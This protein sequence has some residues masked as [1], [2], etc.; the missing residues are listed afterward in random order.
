MAGRGGRQ[1]HRYCA[2]GDLGRGPHLQR[3][4]LLQHSRLRH[5]LLG[6][7]EFKS[8]LFIVQR[9]K[10]RMVNSRP[11][12]ATS[13]RQDKILTME[14]LVSDLLCARTNRRLALAVSSSI[15]SIFFIHLVSTSILGPAAIMANIQ[16][17]S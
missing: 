9:P 13:P 3:Q 17:Q 7:A 4:L 14:L 15:P 16:I 12:L 10:T 1:E 6:S 5:Q 2:L 8:R 11:Y